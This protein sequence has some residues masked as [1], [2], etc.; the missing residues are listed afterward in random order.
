MTDLVWYAAYG[1]NLLAARFAVYLTGGPVPHRPRP[2]TQAGARDPSPPRRWERAE[3][4]HELLFAGAS[5]G[6][7]GGGVAFLD[8]R[9]QAAGE[10][11]TLGRSWLITAEQFEDVFRQEN[12][13]GVPG[14]DAHP[15]SGP[16]A[17]VEVG[18]G[19][20]FDVADLAPGEHIDVA[21]RWYG[22]VLRLADGP[23]GR[24]VATFTTGDPDHP[25][26]AAAQPPYLRTVGLGLIETWG[27]DADDAA[28]RLAA[29]AGNRGVVDPAELAADLRRHR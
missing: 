17:R 3:L 1:S 29:C 10:A 13:M 19:P 7:G 9:A 14:S 22:R 6:W 5:P 8:P 24:P 16:G 23:D 25:P 26:S 11:P 12:G 15:G 18:D 21:G 2:T 4:P 28:A 20:L 27:L